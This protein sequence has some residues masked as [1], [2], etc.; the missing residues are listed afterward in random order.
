MRKTLI[1]I[2]ILSII[3]FGVLW[4]LDSTVDAQQCPGGKC[5]TEKTQPSSRGWRW[6]P[7]APLLP[8][9]Y[10]SP[11]IIRILVDEGK[12]P[13]GAGTGTIFQQ[14]RKVAYVLTAAHV[15]KDRKRNDSAA[16]V[17]LAGD[18]G[19]FEA[20]VLACNVTWDVAILRIADP[21][22][23]P[24][25][26]ADEAPKPGDSIECSGFGPDGAS[27]RYVLGQ[28][29]QFVAPG[30]NLPNEWMEVGVASRP[31][32]SGGPMVNAKGRIVGLI[33]G[34]DGHITAGPCLPRIRRIVNGILG[35][36]PPRSLGSPASI[37]PVC[38]PPL[39]PPGN[40]PGLI[41]GPLPPSLPVPAVIDYDLLAT[42][43]LKQIN[44]DDFRGPAGPPGP[45]GRVGVAGQTGPNGANVIGN[46]GPA[47]PR[48]PTGSYSDLS[49]EEMQDLAERIKEL[50]NG[51]VRVKVDRV[52]SK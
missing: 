20:S 25:A 4:L 44:L 40:T 5:P 21:K 33:N 28:M 46:P 30:K 3:A 37:L 32:D 34:T 18:G 29:I 12:G 8:T 45:V 27:Y 6:A 36:G 26:L 24:I 31:G 51:S 13:Q 1:E 16:V 52:P 38:P 50:I 41:P 17:V 39:P 47:G 35:R 10:P 11:A 9:Y 43:I 2:L 42:A 48:G 19:A 15:V 7:S 23:K 22:I 14:E 49:E